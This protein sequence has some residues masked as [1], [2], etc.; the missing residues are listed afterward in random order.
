MFVIVAYDICTDSKAGQRRLRKVANICQGIG[1]RVQ[2]SVFE[3]QID[4]VQ[5]VQ[6][7]HNLRHVMHHAEDNVRL[8]RLPPLRS[9]MIL[10]LGQ[11]RAVDFT[12]PLIL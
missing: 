11:G 9:E 6:L 8:Y 3:C 5:Y 4:E 10:Q 7:V 1:Q 2:N 12:K